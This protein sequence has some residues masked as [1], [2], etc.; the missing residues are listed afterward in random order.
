MTEPRFRSGQEFEPLSDD[1]LVYRALLRSSWVNEETG[2]VKRD[3]YYLR[4]DRNEIGLSVNI[5]SVCSPED[6]AAR[7]RKCYGVACLS[8]GAIRQIGLD[9]VQDAWSHANIVGL[10]YRENDRLGA[11]RLARL[12][13]QASRIIWQPE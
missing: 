9:V 6:Y 11:D 12:L 2:R 7:F 3:A 10:P 1:V 8:I 13:A 5:A 4:F